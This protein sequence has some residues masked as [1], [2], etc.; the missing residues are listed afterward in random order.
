MD[1]YSILGL[2]KS[3]SQDDI[4]KAYRK[5]A[6]KHHPDRGG[7][8]EK[9]K[10]LQE[11]YEHL[12]NPQTKYEY[13]NPEPPGFWFRMG[14]EP[15][16]F[17]P[18]NANIEMSVTLTAYE[19]FDD[20]KKDIVIRIDGVPVSRTVT[21]PAGINHGQRVVFRGLGDNRINGVPPG[22]LILLV[23]ITVPNGWHKNKLDLH[24]TVD[25]NVFDAILG[26]NKEVSHI[27]GKTLSV[28]FPEGTT[29]EKTIR[30]KGQGYK[31]GSL[32]I[33][34]N[35][36]M[37]TATTEEQRQAIADIKPLFYK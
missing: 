32:F 33:H 13:D 14:G 12:S 19:I 4:K 20:V 18:R 34:P 3:A 24:T 6:A 26:C 5:L 22:D 31:T 37:P 23:H 29:P 30:L 28:K 27:N 2:N 11:A 8:E 36:T 10:E 25:I 17:R 16:E 9:F 7:D 35:I 1:Y 15:F 21:I